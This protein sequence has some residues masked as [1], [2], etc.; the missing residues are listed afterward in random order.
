MIKRKHWLHAAALTTML[1]TGALLSGTAAADAGSGFGIWLSHGSHDRHWRDHRPRHY[2]R[3]RGHD[4]HHDSRRG[5]Y[6]DHHPRGH[7]DRWRHRGHDYR[8]GFYRPQHHY[9]YERRPHRDWIA[10]I[11]RPGIYFLEPD[12]WGHYYYIDHR[13]NGYCYE[14]DRHSHGSLHFSW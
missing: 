4:R 5:R 3:G 7:H 14:R 10:S 9:R 6:R 2:K 1:A 11:R 8:D 13:R 12:H